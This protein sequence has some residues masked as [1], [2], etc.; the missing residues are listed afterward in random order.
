MV[1]TLVNN[2]LGKIFKKQLWSTVPA[3]ALRNCG[4]PRETSVGVKA[5][6]KIGD[7]PNK[8]QKP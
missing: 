8:R 6:I 2:E 4:E 7:L 1:G 5:D 3:I